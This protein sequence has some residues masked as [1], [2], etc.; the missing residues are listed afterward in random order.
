MNSLKD[1]ICFTVAI[2]K[3]LYQRMCKQQQ[4][5]RDEMLNHGSIEAY[6]LGAIT[7]QVKSDENCA[8][9]VYQL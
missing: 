2:P 6:I 1:T 9:E 5:W 4:L 3:S 8:K 7:S